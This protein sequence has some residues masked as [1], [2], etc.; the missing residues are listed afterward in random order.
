MDLEKLK[1]PI[2][3]FHFPEVITAQDIT[4]WIADIEST[5]AKIASAVE[6]LSDKELDTP[7]RPEGWTIRQVIHHLPDSHMNSYI[8]FKWTLTED[9]PTIK[10]YDETLWAELEDGKNAPVE[11]SI[12]LLTALH[13]RWSRVL[14][15]LT[16]TDLEKMFTH[17]ET[18]KKLS[19]K[20]LVALYSWHGRHHLAHIIS[21]KERMNW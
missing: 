2:G 11:M 5:P 8:R 7:Y 16:A 18:G 6:G 3:K 9:E 17:P 12:Q 21:L 19:I 15:N 10:A 4:N 13:I 20:Y 1:Y 14:K